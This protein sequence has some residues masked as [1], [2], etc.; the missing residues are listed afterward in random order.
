[1]ALTRPPAAT[2]IV[3]A[4]CCITLVAFGIR[5]A[6]GLFLEPMTAFHGWSREHFAFALAVQNLLWGAA[7]PVAG[8]IADRH[9]ARPVL[10]A[11][12][13]VYAVGTALMAWAETP[14]WLVLSAGLLIGVGQAFAAF[15]IVLAAFARLLPAADRSWAFGMATAAGSLGQFLLVPLGQAFILAFGWADALLLLALCL[16]LVL[17]L[18]WVLGR[19]RASAE[20]NVVTAALPIG[21]VLSHA[22][23]HRSY[24]LL[25]VGFFVCGFHV[26]FIAVHLPAFLSDQ[27]F[28]PGLGAA[29]L[30]LIGLFNV[31]GAYAAGV[32]GAT[33]S[34]RLLLCWIYL[35]RSVVIL[36]FVSLPMSTVSVALFAAAM[37]LL[38][39]STVPPTSGLV[40]LMFGVRNMAML[41][42]IVFFSHQ[43]GAFV[44]VWLG[45]WL[46]DTTGSYDVVWWLAVALGLFAALVHWPIREASAGEPVAVG[47]GR[48]G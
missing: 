28:A 5:A 19:G 8:A 26:A 9:G 27:G 32:I 29:A 1:M 34:K 4:G 40:A 33:R 25:T 30:A 45:G 44:G 17:P 13:L 6:F 24:L 31:I 47:A 2:L 10:V 14:L 39:L 42:G 48:V 46:F 23:G 36:A 11:G 18:A 43:I 15:T 20:P 35:A 7:Q 22:L 38:W 37:G 21:A 12:L 41:F 3:V 16:V